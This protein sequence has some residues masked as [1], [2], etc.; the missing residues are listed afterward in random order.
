MGFFDR[1][2]K[3]V[4]DQVKQKAKDTITKKVKD[5]L[6]D[7]LEKILSEI[8]AEEIEKVFK[9]KGIRLSKKPEVY[10]DAKLKMRSSKIRGGEIKVSAKLDYLPSERGANNPEL[11]KELQRDFNAQLI[12]RINQKFKGRGIRLAR[13]PKIDFDLIPRSSKKTGLITGAD[14]KLYISFDR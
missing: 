9:G 3:T 11:I 2:K 8:I 10:V 1:F 7:E 5:V 13:R 12:E 4:V 6:V 14:L